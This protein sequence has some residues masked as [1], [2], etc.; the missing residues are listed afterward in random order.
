MRTIRVA[1]VFAIFLAFALAPATAEPPFR[2]E[3]QPADLS[4]M[5]ALPGLHSFASAKLDGYWV[6]VGGRL[7]GNHFDGP[8]FAW[9]KAN[10]NI[11][12][13]HLGT[14]RIWR[15][16]PPP[17][18]LDHILGAANAQHD[19][20]EKRGKLY[21]LGGYGASRKNPD[22]AAFVTYPYL[23]SLDVRRL[24]KILRRQYPGVSGSVG[25]VIQ[26]PNT[27]LHKTLKSR[28]ESR[29]ALAGGRLEYNPDEDRYYLLFGQNCTG[30]YCAGGQQYSFQVRSFRI[31]D[32]PNGVPQI[33]GYRAVTSHAVPGIPPGCADTLSQTDSGVR[34]EKE[35]EKTRVELPDGKVFE[36]V[37]TEDRDSQFRRRDLNAAPI[38]VPGDGSRS[39]AGV[40]AYGGVFTKTGGIFGYAYLNPIYV[41]PGSAPV[42]DSFEQR[43]SHDETALLPVYDS[44]AGDMHTVF[45]GGLSLYVHENG[46]FRCDVAIPYID[47]ISALSRHRNGAS[48]ETVLPARLP[49]LLGTYAVF[50]P[51][52]GSLY[53]DNGV[54]DLGRLQRGQSTLVGWIYGGIKG[55]NQGATT[56]SN[57]LLEVRVVRD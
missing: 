23:I 56:A 10:R 6:F 51:A 4:G 5:P 57:A 21:I 48:E 42:I 52:G 30:L 13:F 19:F 8:Q 20:H 54:L 28:K 27:V 14:K 7:D 32:G 12:V 39:R 43:L 49:D 25:Q 15:I 33:A 53:F 29:V 55:S 1:A 50:L 38:R 44:A 35:G 3:V 37:E 11:W 36:F 2:V 18:P 34:V 41:A 47:T 26:V 46:A 16:A 17:A 24:V 9:D 31:F 45:F 22:S 40:A